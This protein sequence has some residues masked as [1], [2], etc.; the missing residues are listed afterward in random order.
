MTGSLSE[1]DPLRFKPH[2]S[3]MM[4]QLSSEDEGEDETEEGQSGAS[5]EIWGRNS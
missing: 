2:P 3:N 4:S 5:E 1:N